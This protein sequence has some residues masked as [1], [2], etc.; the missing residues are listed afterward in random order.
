[1]WIAVADGTPETYYL[2]FWALFGISC[3]STIG[4]IAMHSMTSGWQ[5]RILRNFLKRGVV[6][7]TSNHQ[8]AVSDANNV[9]PHSSTTASRKNKAMS[10]EVLVPQSD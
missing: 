9:Q 3:D 7:M 6:S 10:S 1:M 2:R 8:V 4:I 5:P